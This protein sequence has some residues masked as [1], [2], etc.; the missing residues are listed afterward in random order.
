MLIA[1]T[2]NLSAVAKKNTN[3]KK[4]DILTLT[5]THTK[6]QTTNTPL[7]A[8]RILPSSSSLFSGPVQFVFRFIPVLR[9]GGGGFCVCRID[10]WVLRRVNGGNEDET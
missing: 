5:G 10:E 3:G 7:S 1:P 4:S 9:A 8:R 2:R 6:T